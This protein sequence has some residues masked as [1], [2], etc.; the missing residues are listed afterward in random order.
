MTDILPPAGWPNVR[1]LETNEFATGGANGNMNEQAKSLAARSELLKKYAALPY[2]SKTGGYALNER[3]QLAT[4]DIVRSTIASNVNNPN[5]NMTGWVKT[6]D[7]SQI[8]YGPLNQADINYD[9][10]NTPEKY[11]ADASAED[12]T[13]ALQ[14]WLDSGKVLHIR[15]FKIYKFSGTLT[16]TVTDQTIIGLT[17]QKYG[18]ARL[19]YTGSGTALSAQNNVGYFSPESWS[20]VCQVTEEG[21]AYKPGTVGIDIPSGTTI[22]AFKWSLMGFER[23]YSGAGTSYYNKFYFCRFSDFN[24]GFYNIASYNNNFVGCRWNKF[25]KALRVLGG[26]GPLNID[27]CS[28]ERF[29]GNIVDSFASKC[30]VNF[31]NNYVEI[32]DNEALPLHYTQAS[33][34][35]KGRFW[36]GNVLFLGVFA[37]LNINKNQLSMAGVFRV[38]N[39]TECDALDCSGNIVSLYIAGNNLDRLFQNVGQYTSFNV[40]DI[41]YGNLGADGGYTRTYIRS[42]VALKNIKNKYFYYDCILDKVQPLL[43]S[44]AIINPVNGWSANT[45]NEPNI[46]A[47]ALDDGSTF[48][49][50]AL[51]GTVKTSNVALTVP[52][53]HRP[54]ELGVTQASCVLRAVNIADGVNVLFKYTY[55]N[56]ELELMTTNPPATL[57]NV[58]LNFTIPPRR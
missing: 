41:I 57:G 3:V 52:T 22:E 46:G 50:G 39:F 40:N 54:I 35:T 45:A 14:S 19:L 30:L 29:N 48:L 6:N 42:P 4:G 10:F 1:Q 43:A 16:L 20:L 26:S 44:L 23:L 38:G 33:N 32:M 9:L 24:E 5:E 37:S 15:P 12:N 21:A 13:V 28:F 58:L 7:A 25:T 36:G 56:G 11:G 55:S 2:E 51:Y 47:I 18:N 34:Q 27:H 17:H 53:S 8:L 31:T 49:V